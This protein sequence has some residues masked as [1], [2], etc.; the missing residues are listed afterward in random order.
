VMGS[1]F[2]CIVI[3]TH[4][5]ETHKWVLTLCLIQIPTIIHEILHVEWFSHNHLFG[6]LYLLFTF[7]FVNFWSYMNLCLQ[8]PGFIQK[9]VIIS[10]TVLAI[11]I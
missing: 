7:Q 1:Y 5:Q 9:I 10:T 8:D 3:L 4:S 2:L 6:M 11:W